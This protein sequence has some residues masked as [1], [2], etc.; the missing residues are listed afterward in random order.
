MCEEEEAVVIR[1]SITNE[2]PSNAHRTLVGEGRQGGGDLKQEEEEVKE[3]EEMLKVLTR[4]VK[5]ARWGED[6]TY[7]HQAEE[8][9]EGEE[10][11]EEEEAAAVAAAEEEGHLDE[12]GTWAQVEPM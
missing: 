12:P 10:E 7:P 3:E 9:E 6:T 1:D 11:E 2:D 4:H 5:Q 8:E